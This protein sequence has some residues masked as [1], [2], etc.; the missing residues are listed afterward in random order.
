[1]HTTTP[2]EQSIAA[3]LDQVPVPDMADSI[4]ASIDLQLGGPVDVP[5]KKAPLK[6]GGKIWYVFVGVV[7]V[8][9]TLWWYGVRKS[10]PPGKTIPEKAVPAMKDSLPVT[11]STIINEEKIRPVT[12]ATRKVDST[13]PQEPVKAFTNPDSVVDKSLPR[14][15]IDSPAVQNFRPVVP[16]V[17]SAAVT[18]PGKRPK[19]VKGIGPDDYRIS[20]GKDS[21]KKGN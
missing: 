6:Y 19:G 8:V 10:H 4:W 11:D 5:V 14:V 15:V 18:P 17:D 21:T 3:K 9:T 1:M 13:S 20:A 16:L 2:Y 7:A 12:P